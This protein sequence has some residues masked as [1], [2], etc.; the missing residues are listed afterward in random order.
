[1][2]LYYLINYRFPSFALSIICNNFIVNL[3]RS[4]GCTSLSSIAIRLAI[5]AALSV[6]GGG[7]NDGILIV[8]GCLIALAIS[9][10]DL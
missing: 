9:S 7:I 8:T 3:G 10:S 2:T 6:C 5:A 1:M 4:C